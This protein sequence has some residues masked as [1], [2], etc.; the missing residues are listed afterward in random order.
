MLTHPSPH[1]SG[2]VFVLTS[3]MDWASEGCLSILMETVEAAGI[4]PMVFATH[5]SNILED[6]LRSGRLEVGLHPNFLPNSTHGA[7]PDK[8]VEHLRCMF[9]TA[10]AFRSHSYV[11]SSYVSLK[12]RDAGFAFDSNLCLQGQVG[13]M[14]LHHWTGLIRY[15]VFWED[16]IHWLRGGRW[17][18]AEQE[19]A[20]FTPGLK[21][22]NVHPFNLALNIPD[23]SWYEKMRN[24]ASTLTAAQARALAF[25]GPGTATFL[26]DL[27]AAVRR[28]GHRFHSLSLVHDTY[29]NQTKC[30][31]ESVVTLTKNS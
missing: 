4:V 8:V 17:N 15:P 2:P 25:A 20:F 26:S 21:I 18:F 13:L 3:D 12:L 10:R 23:Q 24:A 28:R 7:T 27:I 6:G 1:L 9:P 14:P 5:R 16:D 31:A 11:E 29:I 30:E 19:E 22:I